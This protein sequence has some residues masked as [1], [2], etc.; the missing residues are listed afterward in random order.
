ME[1]DESFHVYLNSEFNK[2]EFPKNENTG[3]TNIINPGLKISSDYEVANVNV[4]FKPD[5]FSIKKF[6]EDYSITLL[7]EYVDLLDE[8]N[9]IALKFVPEFDI[10]ARNT[11]D[12]INIINTQF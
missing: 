1:G 12:L 8:T 2:I 5:F 9:V 11:H 4:I 10:R 3:F 7:I 6:D